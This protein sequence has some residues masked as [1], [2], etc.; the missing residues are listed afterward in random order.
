MHDVSFWHGKCCGNLTIM[1]TPARGS[2]YP[3]GLSPT[4]GKPFAH[5]EMLSAAQASRRQGSVSNCSMQKR[6]EFRRKSYRIIQEEA[7]P[8]VNGNKQHR[9]RKHR[10]RLALS[11]TECFD[12]GNKVN[13]H[14][15]LF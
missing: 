2:L 5:Q 8:G 3:S 10:V 15:D 9:L 7:G 6:N 4:S 11:T 12:I 13:W 1:A 14:T